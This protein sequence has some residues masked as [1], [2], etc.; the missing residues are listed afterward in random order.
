MADYA[1]SPNGIVSIK[2][3]ADVPASAT[4]N[5]NGKGAKNVYYRGSAI[6]ANII[7][8]GDTATFMYDGTQYHLLCVDRSAGEMTDTE[9]SDL[10]AALS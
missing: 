5:I 1:L 9:V 3:G 7:Q 2:F 8:A 4:L 10:I 6:T